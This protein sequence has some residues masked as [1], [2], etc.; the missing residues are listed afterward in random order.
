GLFTPPSLR[1]SISFPGHNGGTSWGNTAVDPQ[2][3]RF[4]VVS[5]ETPVLIKLTPPK[6]DDDTVIPNRGPEDL[7]YGAPYDFL[8]QSNGMVA[9]KPP[10]S[11]LTAYDMNSGNILWRIPDGARWP[12]REQGVGD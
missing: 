1:G 12:P 8:R 9:I 2:R 4:F 6:A 7:A 5:R 3:Q 11:F 10:F